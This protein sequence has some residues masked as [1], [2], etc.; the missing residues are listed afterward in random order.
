VGVGEGLFSEGI[1]PQ[2]KGKDLL[3]LVAAPQKDLAAK[4]RALARKLLDQPRLADP[5][6][7]GEQDHMPPTA[8]GDAQLPPETGELGPATDQGRFEHRWAGSRGSSATASWS[9]PRLRSRRDDGGRRFQYSL[10]H[11]PRLEL[12]IRAELSL[13]HVNADLVLAQRRSTSPVTCVEPQQCPVDRLL[14]GIEQQEAPGD[15]D[16]GRDG[17]G[18][19]VLAETLPQCL[20]RQLAEAL[21][22][23][24]QPRLERR[25]V[26]HEPLEQVT[27]VEGD[28]TV[29]RLGLA[30]ADIP[31]QGDGIDLDL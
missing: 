27:L 20:E 18:P 3:A 29:E 19:D 12:G 2:S 23:A 1:D 26:D 30:L 16:R 21:P 11:L 4:T 28:G 25:L 5:R 6:I 14:R 15:P 10:I 17:L 22:L 24:E 9:H 13:E 31:L 8:P 7:T